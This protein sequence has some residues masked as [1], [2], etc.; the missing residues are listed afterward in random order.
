MVTTTKTTCA[1][2]CEDFE[3]IKSDVRENGR[4]YHQAC[5]RERVK[6]TPCAPFPKACSDREL[7]LKFTNAMN[8]HGE[9]SGN[10]HR[11]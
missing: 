1:Y 5:W 8:T 9:N 6:G 10:E 7:A 11:T 4:W 2:C 3:P